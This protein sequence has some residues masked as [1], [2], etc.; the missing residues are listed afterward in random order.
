MEG[1]GGWRGRGWE[2]GGGGGGRVEGARV[3]WA[4]KGRMRGRKVDGGESGLQASHIDQ[5]M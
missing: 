4:E 3:V 2:G 1:A 5:Q